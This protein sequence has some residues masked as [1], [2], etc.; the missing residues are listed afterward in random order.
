MY[1]YLGDYA[2]I[3]ATAFLT[4]F[5]VLF[6]EFDDLSIEFGKLPF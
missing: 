3:D 5:A 2:C 6:S 4:E 1:S